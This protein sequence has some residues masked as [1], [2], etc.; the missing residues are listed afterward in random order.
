LVQQR[1]HLQAAV[2]AEGNVGT[3]LKLDIGGKSVFWLLHLLLQV[4]SEDSAVPAVMPRQPY[5]T[6][7]RL[8]KQNAASS[9]TAA[10]LLLLLLLL[11]AGTMR[12]SMA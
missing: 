10:L 3:A 4:D 2:L 8:S 7:L 1:G 5:R 12:M 9:D 11:P 6:A